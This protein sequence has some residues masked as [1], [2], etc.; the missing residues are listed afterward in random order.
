MFTVLVPSWWEMLQVGM[1]T[2]CMLSP[3]PFLIINTASA[4]VYAL[5]YYQP[6]IALV[7]ATKLKGL[8]AYVELA[9]SQD[10]YNIHLVW[11]NGKSD[12]FALWL[13]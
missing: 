5:L 4:G 8:H 13:R 10:H 12:Q 6:R 1:Q 7:P 2:L 3:E 11:T 9:R